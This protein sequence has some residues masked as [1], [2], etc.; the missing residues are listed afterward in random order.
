MSR[1]SE[2]SCGKRSDQNKAT[3]QTNVMPFLFLLQLATG[4][5]NQEK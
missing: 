2:R 3:I 4:F 1:L 5:R